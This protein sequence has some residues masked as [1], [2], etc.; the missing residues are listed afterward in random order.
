MLQNANLDTESNALTNFSDEEVLR[1]EKELQKQER[2]K[3]SV[4]QTKLTILAVQIGKLGTWAAALTVLI[5][6]LR[7]FIEVCHTPFSVIFS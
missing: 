5:L 6:F 1:Q 4:L 3:T 7:F 2:R